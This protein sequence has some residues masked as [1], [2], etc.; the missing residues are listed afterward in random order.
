MTDA[1]RQTPLTIGRPDLLVDGGDAGFRVLVHR[2][3][4]FGSRLE[5]IRAGLGRMI[6]LSGP[7]YTILICIAHLQDGDGSGVKEIADHLSYS[8]A[9]I[10]QEAGRLAEQG[11][12]DKRQ[13]PLD[14]R[15]VLMTVTPAGRALL[16]RLA[17]RQRQVNDALFA[18][19]DRA[20]FERLAEISRYLVADADSALAL[21]AALDR[22]EAKTA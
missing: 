9:F 14:R 6:G 15:R 20:D 18:S 1:R 10:T 13:N 21:I 17:P 12:V 22:P 5:A 16:D 2:L 7:Q 19:M 3:L 8:G 11:L 4:A